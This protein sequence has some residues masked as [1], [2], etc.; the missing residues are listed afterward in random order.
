MITDVHF[1]VITILMI[2]YETLS[3]LY[4]TKNGQQE[5]NKLY[6]QICVTNEVSL[7][8]ESI[9]VNDSNRHSRNKSIGAMQLLC[10]QFIYTLPSILRLL[11]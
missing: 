8:K 3:N 2:P 7:R 5:L 10:M 9:I 6:I 1:G 11:V 4:V